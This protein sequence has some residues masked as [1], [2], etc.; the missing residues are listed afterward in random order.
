MRPLHSKHCSYAVV[1]VYM[2]VSNPNPMDTEQ[3]K[4]SILYVLC[5][6]GFLVVWGMEVKLVGQACNNRLY[7]NYELYMLAKFD[8]KGALIF[9]LYIMCTYFVLNTIWNV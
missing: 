2:L 6:L 4:G 1:Y 9:S 7:V 3:P 5:Q 8:L